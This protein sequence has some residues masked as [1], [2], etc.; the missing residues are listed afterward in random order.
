[1]QKN[2][3]LRRNGV[4]LSISAGLA[5]NPS[6]GFISYYASKFGLEGLT[7]SLVTEKESMGF[8]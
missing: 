1:M 7:R 2:M 5:E 8:V 3:I 4:V 6:S